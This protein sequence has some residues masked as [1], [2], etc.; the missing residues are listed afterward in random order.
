MTRLYLS[1]VMYLTGV[2]IEDMKKG[3]EHYFLS[4]QN[5]FETGNTSRLMKLHAEI[6]RANL[7]PKI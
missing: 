5:S 4:L 2:T 1:S 6:E 3:I 7:T